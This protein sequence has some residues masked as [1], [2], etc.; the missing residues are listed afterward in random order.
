MAEAVPD[1]GEDVTAVM[2]SSQQRTEEGTSFSLKCIKDKKVPIAVTVVIAA[3]LLT[4]IALAAK[5]CPSC[6]SCPSPVLS[7]LGE[8]IGYGDKCFYFVE[9]EA[10][11]NRSQIFCLSLGAHLATIDSRGD[12]D[13]L[14]RYAANR[15]FW[16]GLQREN[17]G[18]WK[19][20]NGSLLNNLFEVRG[21]G[22]CAYVNVEGISSDWCSQMKYSVCSHLQKHP[23]R[24]LK[25]SEFLLNFTSDSPSW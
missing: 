3:L 17:T 4:I 5:K 18:P 7:C 9:A 13:F 10:D 22:Q 19:W 8:E 2:M 23:S 11:W 6:P 12:L 15:D 24:I 16:F 20:F 25:D 21:N 14:L 1:A